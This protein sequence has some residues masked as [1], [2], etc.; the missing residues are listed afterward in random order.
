M[1]LPVAA[2][3]PVAVSI[4]LA[5]GLWLCAGCDANLPVAAV[6]GTITFEGKPLVG[7]SITTQPI[8]ANSTNPGSGSFGETDHQGRFELELVK[9]AV[10]GA[11]IGEHRVIISPEVGDK[12]DIEPRRSAEGGYEYWTDDPHAKLATIANKWPTH[13]TDGSLRLQ[14]PPEGAVNV[15]LDLKR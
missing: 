15:R 2:R 1:Q 6:S 4:F 7:A 5:L 9:P 14:V 13:F 12:I 3:E 8:S 11:I 10:K